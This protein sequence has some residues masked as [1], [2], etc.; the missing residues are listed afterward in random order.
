MYRDP[1][2]P[3]V[4]AFAILLYSVVTWSGMVAFGRRDWG[5]NG[6]GFRV[7]FGFLSRVS[8]FGARSVDG[9]KVAVLR[10]PLSR[11]AEIERRPGVVAF[12][13]TMLGSVAFD[14]LSRSSWWLDR[15][16]D[17]QSSIRTQPWPIA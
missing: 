14:G 17:I 11:L 13:A 16:Y 3:R 1:A 10:Q 8:L 2:R 9:R 4:L 6:D 15:V 12:F 7:Y 5:L